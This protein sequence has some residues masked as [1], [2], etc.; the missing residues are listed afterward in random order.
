MKPSSHL[1]IQSREG[2]ESAS[3]LVRGRHVK[4]AGFSAH[5]RSNGT[6]RQAILP[7]AA[8]LLSI[9]ALTAP[10]LTVPTTGQEPLALGVDA[11]VEGN[12]P[13]TLGTIDRQVSVCR[14]DEFNVD[15]YIQNVN[16]LLA[17]ETYVGFD[18]AVL[19]VTGRDVKM[20]LAGNPGS[21]VLDVSGH[22]PEPGLYP[23][24]AADTSDPPTPDSGSGVLA[25]LTVKTVDQ[26]TSD[27]ELIIRDVDDDGLA[28]LGPLLRNVDGEVLGD[29]NGDTIFDG[30]IENAEVTV[31]PA[32]DVSSNTTPTAS[33]DSGVS[34][35][36][37]AL[38][39]A[40]VAAALLIAGVIAYRRVR[41]PRTSSG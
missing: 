27:I 24:A 33:T 36:L 18:P 38:A 1:Q 10:P 9:V 26:G 2:D 11:N 31:D 29:T 19:K 22:V 34:P 13:L 39:A 5:L 32:C 37:I 28:D 30:S 14:G 16:E 25:R 23:V 17:W 12:G 6:I 21:S 8:L 41:G 4:S 15:I 7:I 40:G 3:S 20:F 35:I